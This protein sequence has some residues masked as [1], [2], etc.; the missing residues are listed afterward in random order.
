MP[1]NHTYWPHA[2]ITPTSHIFQPYISFT[3]K[4]FAHLTI[5][6]C[7]LVVIHACAIPSAQGPVD[8][9]A[10]DMFNRMDHANPDSV[11][12][13]YSWAKVP[14]M[15]VLF[16]NFNFVSWEAP[17]LPSTCSLHPPPPP[18]IAIAACVT[19][20]VSISYKE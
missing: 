8:V 20:F 4:N 13:S 7:S 18:P 2:L 17:V 14:R 16:L 10:C 12:T 9:Y 15:K 3:V 6:L 11:C 5:C 1:S 19:A